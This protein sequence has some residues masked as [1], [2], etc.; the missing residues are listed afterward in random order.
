MP[1]LIAENFAPLHNSELFTLPSVKTSQF[2]LLLLTHLSMG[3]CWGQPGAGSSQALGTGTPIKLPCQDFMLQAFLVHAG[4]RSVNNL[5][6]LRCHSGTPLRESCGGA[7]GH[8]QH[9]CILPHGAGNRGIWHMAGVLPVEEGM[10][11]AG[12]RLWCC[13]DSE[14]NAQHGRMPARPAL[15]NSGVHARNRNSFWLPLHPHYELFE[16]LLWIY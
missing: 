11:K 9:V 4:C 14:R 6:K 7:G 8:S 2:I 1:G 3:R 10:H 5:S 13:G 12:A 16:F 15:L